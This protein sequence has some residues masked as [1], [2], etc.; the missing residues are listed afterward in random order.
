MGLRY[1][2][3]LVAKHPVIANVGYATFIAVGVWHVIGGSA[4]WLRISP[5][6]IVEG[7]D[8]GARRKRKRRRLIGA[9]TLGVYLVW[10]AGGLGVVGRWGAG[11]GWEAKNWDR[12]YASVP[13]VGKWI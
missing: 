9:T 7:G 6:Y 8:Y 11:T 13:L 10:I 2:A 4:K 1:F 3:H 12:I 5:E